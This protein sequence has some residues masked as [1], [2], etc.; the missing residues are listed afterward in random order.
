MYIGK[1]RLDYSVDKFY[2]EIIECMKKYKFIS[3]DNDDVTIY[4]SV[5]RLIGKTIDKIDDDNEQ[6]SLFGGSNEL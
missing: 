5:G 1:T 2:N 3:I 6:I 4:P